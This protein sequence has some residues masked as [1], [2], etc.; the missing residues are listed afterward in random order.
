MAKDKLQGK[1][2][3]KKQELRT[4]AG[5]A[6][7]SITRD[8]TQFPNNWLQKISN[9][10]IKMSKFDSQLFICPIYFGP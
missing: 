10:S 5:E 9:K 3:K 8:E 4:V 7:Q 2:L 6:L 1:R